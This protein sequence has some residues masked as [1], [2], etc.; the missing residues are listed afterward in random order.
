MIYAYFG[1]FLIYRFL[2][3]S[4][5]YKTRFNTLALDL[6]IILHEKETLIGSQSIKFCRVIEFGITARSDVFTI[7]RR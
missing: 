3:I 4:T 1:V 2:S 5:E 6:N 7:Q